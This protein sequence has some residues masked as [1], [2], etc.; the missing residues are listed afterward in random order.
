M[1]E[2]LFTIGSFQL[3]TLNLI[4]VVAFFI[5]AF[6][7]WKRGKEEHYSEARLIDAFLLSFLFGLLTGRLAFILFNFG[8]FG[9]NLLKWVNVIQK[10]GS[11][12]IFVL[13]GA[14]AH[15][16]IFAQKNKWDAFEILDFAAQALVA[17]LLWLNIGYFFE[18]IRFGQSTQLPWGIIFPGV[19]E[20]RHPV[21]LYYVAFH[22]IF[23]RYLSW[24]EYNY[25]TFEWYRGRKKTAKTGF[26]FINLLIFYS[27]FSLLML[28]V[29]TPVLVIGKLQVDIWLYLVFLLVGLWL[30]L[31]RA[32]RVLFSFKDKKFFAL[33]K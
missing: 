23:G 22:L 25:R 7:F 24:L 13:V 16:F 6:V 9:W 17:G 5:A 1:L 4:Q 8:N 27:L 19:F 2:T 21:Q 12:L 29:Q 33:R 26:L 18:G 10:P 32:N 20:K 31:K 11:Q 14:V 15:L 3:K 30:L 28:L